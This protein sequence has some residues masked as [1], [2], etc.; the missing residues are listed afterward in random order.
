VNLCE[1][2]SSA[3]RNVVNV[4]HPKPIVGVSDVSAY[5]SNARQ[6]RPT[7]KG[8]RLTYMILALLSPDYLFCPGGVFPLELVTVPPSVPSV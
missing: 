6:K 3:D 4:T 2:K 1:L 5:G 7:K 8:G